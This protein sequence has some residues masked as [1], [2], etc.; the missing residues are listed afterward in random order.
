MENLYAWFVD[1]TVLIDEAP[2]TYHRR[3]NVA[4]HGVQET[5]LWSSSTPHTKKFMTSELSFS[6][7][8]LEFASNI[9]MLFQIFEPFVCFDLCIAMEL[10]GVCIFFFHHPP[11]T[12]M[13]CYSWKYFCKLAFI[14][15]VD[16]VQY[17]CGFTAVNYLM[18]SH[19][20]YDWKSSRRSNEISFG[21]WWAI[22]F[23]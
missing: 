5:I 23:K 8:S 22:N 1:T 7:S 11:L 21:I 20:C 18:F 10:L 6:I 16:D 4:C 17:G 13:W 2:L 12:C 15:I 14:W 19:S 9:Y 3:I